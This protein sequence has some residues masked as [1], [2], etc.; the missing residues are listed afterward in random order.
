MSKLTELAW[1]LAGETDK[2][3]HSIAWDFSRK[4]AVPYV[5]SPVAGYLQEVNRFLF[6]GGLNIDVEAAESDDPRQLFVNHLVKYNNLQSSLESVWQT[7]AIT[8]E[9]LIVLRLSQ[10]SYSFEWFDKTE[11]DYNEEAIKVKTVRSID[12]VD[13]VYKLDIT[14]L[15]YIEYPL[16][17]TRYASTFNWEANAEP[18]PHTYGF[19]PASVIKNQIK[20]SSRRGVGEFNF[21]ACK[22]A[23]AVLMATFDAFENL[24]LFGNP[25]FISPDPDDTLKRLRAR[26]QVLQKE[27]NEDGGTIDILNPSA[28]SAEHLQFIG[29][30]QDNF[31][32]HMGVKLGT[33]IKSADVS[34]LTLRILNSAT[35]S[36]AEAKWQNY[37]EDGLKV[38][39]ERCLQMSAIDGI[40]L[41][42]NLKD[43]ATYQLSF[44]R[45]KPYFVE[46]P[47]EISQ[48]LT[49]A[50]QLVDLGVDR[51]E[52]LKQTVWP[53]LSYGQIE[54][55]LRV[56]LEDI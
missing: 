11:F 56:N 26:V 4:Q 15:A 7:G 36:R 6:D 10:G 14:S 27:A 25:F 3:N 28:I 24:R 30:L 48:Q 38:A 29:A 50:Q 46:S 45:K 16:V 39:I 13:Y 51:V 52:A 12:G 35:I 22:L 37:V 1:Y 32:H 34:S 43:Y 33:E 9:L 21:G 54:E 23:A 19:I 31:N 20:L 49:V 47:L 2:N 55:K 17:E 5:A 8:G 41:N 18:V 42:V 40:L 53:G 44:N